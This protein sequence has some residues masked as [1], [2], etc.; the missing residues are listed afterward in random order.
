M[1]IPFLPKTPGRFLTP[2]LAS[3][4]LGAALNS[5]V[6]GE[7]I[8]APTGPAFSHSGESMQ[9]DEDWLE[10]PVRHDPAIGRADLV[11]N[12]DQ[13]TGP[14][15]QPIIEEYAQSEN[16]DIYINS[17]TCGVSNRLLLKKQLDLG[18]YCCPPGDEDR[19]PGLGFHTL[20]ISPIIFIVPA[21]NPLENL[22]F[23]EAQRIFMG[24]IKRWKELKG[25]PETS[26]GE[27]L[28]QPVAFI[29]CKTRPGHWRL[30]LENEDLFA[31]RLTTVLTIPDMFTT[32]AHNPRAI[33]FDVP[34]TA[35]TFHKKGKEQ[36][37]H[38]RL[39][40]VDPLELEHLA[41]GR[42]PLYRTLN[43]AVWEKEPARKEQAIQLKDHLLEFMA[44]NGA[45]FGVVDAQRLRR[46][47]WKFN[48]NEL[49]GP[50]GNAASKAKQR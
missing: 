27:Q 22:S 34:Y 23:T 18:S 38:V 19:F 41:A 31:P 39:D 47:G 5:P 33:G 6:A 37:K 17:G 48:G 46:A 40:D 24:E 36:V 42:Y 28:I 20:G 25:F 29:H 49:A 10:Q 43:L 1:T 44:R 15:L 35:L 30:L 13:S 3:L 16:L 50:P 9:M 26:D 12:L 11:V 45:G 32:V 8:Y 14:I 2:L 4:L 7:D 21:T